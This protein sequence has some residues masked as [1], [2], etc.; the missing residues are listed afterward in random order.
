MCALK[1]PSSTLMQILT[2]TTQ[3]D[4][5]EETGKYLGVFVELTEGYDEVTK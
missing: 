2:S 1:L 3:N 4:R 5:P